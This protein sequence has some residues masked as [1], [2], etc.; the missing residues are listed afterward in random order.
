M[1]QKPAPE[2]GAVG[3]N[4]MPDSGASF[5]C[6]CGGNRRQSTMLE[7]VHWHEKLAPE[8]GIE[9]TALISGVGFWSMCVCLRTAVQT[10][11]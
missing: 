3:V 6:R 8:S 2:I 5:S 11:V 7:V 9:V 10:Q 4:S 1:L